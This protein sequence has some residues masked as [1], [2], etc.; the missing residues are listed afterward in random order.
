MVPYTEGS[1]N[2]ENVEQDLETLMK[3]PDF[4]KFEIITE[5]IHLTERW[6]GCGALN[7][8]FFSVSVEKLDM[9]TVTEL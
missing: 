3:R 5:N 9:V 6:V 7:Y 4:P 2:T 1:E 8:L